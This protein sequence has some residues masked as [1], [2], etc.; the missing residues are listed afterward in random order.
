MP[1]NKTYTITILCLGIILSVWLLQRNNVKTAVKKGDSIFVAIDQAT[2]NNKNSDWSKVLENINSKSEESVVPAVNE[3][4]TAFDETTLTAQM[5]RDLF[6]R[7]L[8][9]SKSGETLTSDDADKIVNEVLTSSDYMKEPQ[10]VYIKSNL[11]ITQKTDLDTLKKYQNA[12][13]QILTKRIAEIKLKESVVTVL[14]RSLAEEKEEKLADLDPL[15]LTNKAL[16]SDFLHIE[17]PKEVVSIHLDLLNATNNILE[18]IKGMRGMFLDPIKGFIA[19]NQ[20]QK[21][22]E[23]FQKAL[24]DLN[25]YYRQKFG[26]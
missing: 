17:V 22:I 14:D 18:N 5:A 23:D 10:P 13:N 12:I 24:V 4:S 21:H 2:V 19:A 11:N 1:S 15:I 9:I 26:I 20:Y 6:S 7:Y 25:N 8:L 3:N 16:V